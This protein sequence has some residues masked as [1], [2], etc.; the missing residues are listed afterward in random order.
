MRGND[1]AQT[2]PPKKRGV[3]LSG[4]GGSCRTKKGAKPLTRRVEKYRLLPAGPQ[5]HRVI[6]W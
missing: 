3:D 1:I 2:T 6:P 4:A 5:H